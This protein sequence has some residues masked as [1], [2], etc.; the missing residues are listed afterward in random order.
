M[1]DVFISYARSDEKVARRLA[2][3]LQN[4]G[5]S[6]WWDADLPAHR[7]YSDEIESQLRDAKAVVVLWSKNAIKSQW[8]RAE[9]DSAR[10]DRKLVQLSTDGTIPPM[11]FNQIQCADLTG[12]RGGANHPG[13]TKAL[14]SLAALTSG[15]ATRVRQNPPAKEWW[16]QTRWRLVAGALVLLLVAGVFLLPDYFADGD[17]KPVVAVL[18]FESLDNRDQSLVAGIWEDTRQAIGRNPQ[19]VVLGPNT[20]E[21]IAEK[22]SKTAARLAN[23]LVEASVRSTGDRVR[24]SARL[25]RTNDGSEMWS[26]SFDRSLDD[27]FAL[28]SEMAS[29]IEGHIRGR[30]AERGGIR[31][32]NI[33]TSGEVY[34]LYSDA[35]AKIRKRQLGRYEE[36]HKQLEQVVRMDPN[37]APGWAALAVVKGFVMG[38]T[39]TRAGESDARRAIALA[40]NLAA[41]HAALG[42]TLGRSPA[43][44]AAL[45][46]AL[47]IDPNDFEAIHWLANSM[48]PVSQAEERLRLYSKI[49][50]LEPLWWPAVMN[51]LNTLFEMGRQTAIDAELAR[52]KKLGDERMTALMLTEISQRRGDLSAAV[53]VALSYYKNS[54]GD[55]RQVIG[56]ALMASLY[57]LGLTEMADQVFP[58]PNDYIPYLRQNDP[59]ALD[60]IEKQY[61]PRGF[62]TYGFLAEVGGRVYLLNNFGPRLARQYRAVATN[63]EQFASVV[64]EQRFAAIAPIAALALRSVGD[65]TQAQ[66]LLRLAE[67]SASI[68]TRSRS[69]RL[70]ALARIHAVQGR[71]SRAISELSAA[72][73]A[74]WLPPYLPILPDI[75][76]DP[77]LNELR[78]DSK[79]QRLRQQILGHLAKERAEL[80]TISLD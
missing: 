44:Q 10:N 15:E 64:G 41:G 5:Y 26:Q 37:F 23:Y 40:P 36:A 66:E 73:R 80:G 58:P 20:A 43:A 34:A 8:V 38:S 56:Q 25:V 12:W 63:A 16:A 76:L 77:P 69:D 71:S 51:K 57:Q 1:A 22:G 68:A 45:R 59:K 46:R 62:W 28:Q 47:A 42:F 18:P 65:E 70:V 78:T 55:E 9:A 74:G 39:D 54:S 14:D 35:R 7:S 11:P 17:K 50:E 27:V 60:M 53:N 61:P 29:A 72:I 33:A 4:T 48:D 13:V 49:I 52:V 30:L 75:A 24:V 21:E 19:L 79:F 32:E 2:T 3:M 6:L 67:K 31:P